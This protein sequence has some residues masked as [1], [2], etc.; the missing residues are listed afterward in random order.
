MSQKDK[1]RAL[2]SREMYPPHFSQ[3]HNSKTCLLSSLLSR[4]FYIPTLHSPPLIIQVFV[5]F[6]LTV[7][8]SNS[9][10][11]FLAILWKPIWNIKALCVKWS[12]KEKKKAGWHCLKSL[13]HLQTCVCNREMEHRKAIKTHAGCYSHPNKCNK[14][15]KRHFRID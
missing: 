2:Q 6:Q 14:Y 4:A 15:H 8:L 5:E 10:F 11:S 12:V 7:H 1:Q 13:W 9:S 3:L